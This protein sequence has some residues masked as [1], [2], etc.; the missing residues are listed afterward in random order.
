MQACDKD[1]VI[2]RPFGIVSYKGKED[3]INIENFSMGNS[4]SKAYGKGL[5]LLN[6]KVLN[7][8]NNRLSDTGS[9]NI[10]RGVGFG[11]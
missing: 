1:H 7:L 2:P 11:V 6:A 10:L 8:S 5:K 9:M 3:E 4:Y